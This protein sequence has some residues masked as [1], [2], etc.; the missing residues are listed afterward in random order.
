MKKR[1][2]IRKF[3]LITAISVLLSCLTGALIALGI[4]RT[5]DK[6]GLG[7]VSGGSQNDKYA[8]ADDVAASDLETYVK[9]FTLKASMNAQER[10]N[11]WDEAIAV[12]DGKVLFVLEDDWTATTTGDFYTAPFTDNVAGQKALCIPNGCK[13]VLDLNGNTINRNLSSRINDGN[14]ITVMGGGKLEICGKGKITGANN[15]NGGCIR[16][17]ANAEMVLN[18]VEI[19]GN[20]AAGGAGIVVNGTLT[21]NDAL[22]TNNQIPDD[23]YADNTYIGGGG[24][25]CGASS[26]VTMNGGTISGNSSIWGGGVSV[27]GGG[28]FIMNGGTISSNTAIRSG[29]GGVYLEGNISQTAFAEF[30]MNGGTITDNTVASSVTDGGGAGVYISA[31]GKFKMYGGAISNNISSLYAGG[32]LIQGGGSY[33]SQFEMLGGTVSGNRSGSG[34]GGGGVFVRQGNDN[35]F[36]MYGGTISGNYSD[37]YGGGV[38]LYGSGSNAKAYFYGG[39]ITGNTA[40][41]GGGGIYVPDAQSMYLYGPLI[42]TENTVGSQANN[43]ELSNLSGNTS[44]NG[45]SGARIN[46]GTAAGYSL[47]GAR[48]Y[49]YTSPYPTSTQYWYIT[50]GYEAASTSLPSARPNTYFYVDNTALT[51][52]W[53]GTGEVYMSHP[54]SFLTYI[55]A[56]WEY[57]LDG[58]TDWTAA[59]SSVVDLTYSGKAIADVRATASCAPNNFTSIQSASAGNLKYI[60]D[61]RT[62]GTTLSSS[63]DVGSVTFVFDNMT[64]VLSS[65]YTIRDCG[66]TINIKPKDATVTIG[67]Q[68]KAEYGKAL[69]YDLTKMSVSGLVGGDTIYSLGLSFRRGYGLNAGTHNLYGDKA[70]N[71]NYNVTFVNGTFTI[72]K[73]DV[74]VIINNDSAAYGKTN[75]MNTEIETKL[76]ATPVTENG[77]Q[78]YE[79]GWRYGKQPDGTDSLMF[80]PE[81]L[82]T[83]K[84]PF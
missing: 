52:I 50:K 77:K 6:G 84:S 74:Y 49:I 16:I 20:V 79:G 48:I 68:Q 75:D 7:G 1:S 47:A 58:D 3:S 13:M 80:H 9:T 30:E 10:G 4:N 78:R 63:A 82:T 56:K 83:S 41:M 36:K 21:V 39:T 19:S 43:V 67:N 72:E 29:G 55:Q 12:T 24:I 35:T 61:S 64:G 22:I 71:K 2:G 54:T 5:F 25:A 66:F 31:Y 34:C 53:D 40:S 57:K 65:S 26:V 18:G 62:G 17:R 27:M 51:C 81:D 37:G 45:G 8:A 15:V 76:N 42:C 69:T 14:V 73:R 46:V 23:T 33:P 38:N 32:V 60:K 11:L 59:T 28:K 44:I 70:T